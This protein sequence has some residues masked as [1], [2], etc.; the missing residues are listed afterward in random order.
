MAKTEVY[1]WRL[2]PEKK[3][4]LEHRA[5][6]RGQSVAQL[7]DHL[8]EEFIASRIDES[9]EAEQRRLHAAVAKTIGTIAGGNPRRSETVEQD[10]YKLLKR[11]H[12][13]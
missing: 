2:S 8:T 12:G 10:I 4:V 11:R 3:R 5:R 7:L 9:G 1:S 6:A 13:R